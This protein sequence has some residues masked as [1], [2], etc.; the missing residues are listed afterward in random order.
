MKIKNRAES[1][2]D[3]KKFMNKL[4]KLWLKTPQQRFGQFLTNYY[5][6]QMDLFYVEDYDFLKYLESS[7]E[8][9]TKICKQPK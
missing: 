2:A 8:R 3:K 1:A 5:I 6:F 4:L 9:Y 7:V